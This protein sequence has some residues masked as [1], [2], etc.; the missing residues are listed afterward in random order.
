MKIKRKEHKGENGKVL[1]IGGS[2][3][4]TGAIILAS[5]AALR[6]GVDIVTVCAPEKVAWTINSYTPDIITR[7]FLGKELD[8]THCK[9]I[10]TL[11]EKFDVIL[12]GNGLGIK[13]DFVN[14]IIR[15]IK[16]PKVIDAD[17]IKVTNI[18]LIENAIL[19]P[20]I[21][22][23]E[24]LFKNTFTNKIYKKKKENI[25][26]IQK[27]MNNNVVLLKG[28]EDLIFNNEKIHKNK[29]GHD[30]MT[31]AG[32]GDILAGLCAGYLAQSKDLFETAKK[33]AYVNGKTG[34]YMYKKKG[35]SYVAGEMLEEMWRFVK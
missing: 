25:T 6:T 19:T 14:K 20:H 34:E 33:A 21:K 17:A 4:Y 2:E 11:S 32:T 18:S 5:I 9:E 3:D 1:A 8:I 31:V 10:I 29:S 22:E 23:F 15:T 16:I 35:Y 28:K 27:V 12:I 24:D 30:S 26:K 7:K 13:K